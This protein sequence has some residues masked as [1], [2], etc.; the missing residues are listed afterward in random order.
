MSFQHDVLYPTINYQT[1][2]PDCDLDY[3]TNEARAS[4]IGTIMS[5]AFGV[6]GNNAIVIFKRWDE[7]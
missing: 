1:P 7:S 6:G 4:R 2:D 3:V 5:N